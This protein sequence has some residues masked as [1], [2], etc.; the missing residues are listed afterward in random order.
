VCARWWALPR[1]PAAALP[2]ALA[3]A[4][5]AAARAACNSWGGSVGLPACAHAPAPQAHQPRTGLGRG[6]IALACLGFRRVWRVRMH[7]L[8]TLSSSALGSAK[9][10]LRLHARVLAGC[11]MRTRLLCVRAQRAPTCFQRVEA[12]C[13]SL[14]VPA[15][16]AGA[17]ADSASLPAACLTTLFTWDSTH[18][19]ICIV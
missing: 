7:L 15:G 9:V 10:G 11:S 13:E 2:G 14:D 18:R 5:R 19:P 4:A 8:I 17:C 12:A 6:A 16:S 3:G 1:R